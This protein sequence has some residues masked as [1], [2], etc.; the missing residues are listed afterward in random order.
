MKTS[1]FLV[2]FL[3]FCFGC[4]APQ[5][6]ND[7]VPKECLE[8]V[9]HLKHGSYEFEIMANGEGSLQEVE[10]RLKG[11]PDTLSGM[12]FQSEPVVGADVAD[13]DGDSY[14]EVLVYSQSAGSGSYGNVNGF[15]YLPENGFRPILFPE[16]SEDFVTNSGYM[17]HDRFSLK[18][19]RLTRSFPALPA[20]STNSQ[21]G[22]SSKTIVYTFLQDKKTPK[23]RMEGDVN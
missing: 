4:S 20:E 3:S 14:P 2:L 11:F 10:V 21:P 22:D 13:L 17:G 1:P 15:S 19:N 5:A 23:F 8:A 16:L 18:G 7:A 6:D 12:R 9:F